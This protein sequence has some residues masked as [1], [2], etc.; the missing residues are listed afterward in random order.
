MSEEDL[1]HEM[2]IWI[3]SYTGADGNL[4]KDEADGDAE[5]EVIDLEGEEG[6]KRKQMSSRSNI[7]DHFTKIYH[8]D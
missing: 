6:K 2:S 1:H 8:E 5:K 4:I 3:E 7:W